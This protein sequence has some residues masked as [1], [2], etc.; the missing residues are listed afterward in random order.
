MASIHAQL[1]LS[2]CP[3]CRV[4]TPSLDLLGKWATTNYA[5]KEQRF[6]GVYECARCGGL[7]TP[8]SVFDGGQ[9]YGIYPSDAPVDAALPDPA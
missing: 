8:F 6:W 2:R 1:E 4:D 7:V 9:A 5:G 3:H